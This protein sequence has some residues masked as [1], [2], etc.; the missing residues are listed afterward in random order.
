MRQLL[1]AQQRD[2]VGPTS[3]CL[4]VSFPLIL[5][6]FGRNLLPLSIGF[7]CVGCIGLVNNIFFIA[8]ASDTKEILEHTDLIA[9]KQ[10]RRVIIRSFCAEPAIKKESTHSFNCRTQ[11]SY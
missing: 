4:S 8:T 6:A 5:S 2:E 3:E 11:A 9:V 7:I 1:H 10:R